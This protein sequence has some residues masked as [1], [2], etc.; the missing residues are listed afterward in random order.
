MGVGIDAFKEASLVDSHVNLYIFM[1]ISHQLYLGHVGQ[2]QV[3][4]LEKVDV[5]LESGGLK[6]MQKL[7]LVAIVN[8]V[9]EKRGEGDR[10]SLVLFLEQIWGEGG[11]R[12][13]HLFKIIKLNK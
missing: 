6:D 5:L 10:V 1:K 7:G 11:H 13:R 4:P 3:V 8:F 9:G 2:L 12:E